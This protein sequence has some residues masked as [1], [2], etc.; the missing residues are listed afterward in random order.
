M[1]LPNYQVTR[2]N[3]VIFS[4]PL[5]G[6]RRSAVSPT[7]Y[8]A[9]MVAT[10]A[11]ACAT[12]SPYRAPLGTP[13]ARKPSRPVTCTRAR[14]PGGATLHRMTKTPSIE[15]VMQRRAERE[16]AR[17]TALRA[18]AD[19]QQADDDVDARKVETSAAVSRAWAAAVAA[20]IPENELRDDG[21]RA[22]AR[23]Q[24]GRPRGTG[25]RRTPRATSA[26][27]AAETPP[28]DSLYGGEETPAAPEP[29]THI[30]DPAP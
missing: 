26:P 13:A 28:P 22:P 9:T 12:T 20:G 17:L 27:A 8:A 30:I 29:A 5:L 24:P 16:Q 14:N 4:P 2:P 6:F 1:R 7:T 10:T 3:V 15:Q 21:F 19:A 23:K 25:T 18:L 11:T